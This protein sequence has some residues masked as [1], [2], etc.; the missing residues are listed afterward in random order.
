VKKL[1]SLG[2]CT[3]FMAGCATHAVQDDPLAG[4][5]GNRWIVY[6]DE[7]MDQF[8]VNADKT[9]SGHFHDRGGFDV[10]GLWAIKNER[11][12][13]TAPDVPNS[14]EHCDS[15]LVGK[16]LGDTWASVDEGEE[17]VSVI[18]KGGD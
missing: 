8:R 11:V 16:R 4:F 17:H 18:R 6:S 9:W 7:G 15:A 13:F 14:K 10:H 12:C 2:L 1:Q 3:L 5:Y